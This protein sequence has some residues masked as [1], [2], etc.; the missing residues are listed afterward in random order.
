M[1][2]PLGRP[3]RH[4]FDL[5]EGSVFLN[6]GSYG[7]TPKS[8]TQARLAWLARIEANPDRFIRLDLARELDRALAAVARPV[9]GCDVTDLA[10]VT[11]SSVGTIA[12][13]NAIR[14]KQ[15]ADARRRSALAPPP[16]AAAATRKPKI[17]YVSTRYVA[18]GTAI[19]YATAVDG[20]EPLEVIVEYPI[21]DADLAARIEAAVQGERAAGGEVAVAIIDAISSVPGVVVP[22]RAL[23][24]LLRRLAVPVHVDAAHAAGQIPV[25]DVAELDPDFFVTNLHK[26]LYAPRSCAVIYVSPRMRPYICSPVITHIPQALAGR[27]PEENVGKSWRDAFHWPGTFDASN[28]LA[29]PAAVQFR[30]RLGGEAR[31]QA[32]CHDLAV[33]GGHLVASMW[34]THMLG[35]EATPPLDEKLCG[36]MCCVKIPDSVPEEVVS[37]AMFRLFDYNAAAV[38]YKEHNSW[39]ARLSAQPYSEM[40]TPQASVRK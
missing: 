27:T 37:S 3:M 16:T 15:A 2:P 18:V 7:A 40:K 28:W 8:V 11:N 32:Y 31:I 29:V 12:V 25:A 1:P 4:E 33:R 6:H 39:W 35:A 17:L 38:I 5:E 30:E 10:F 23:V 21:A 24:R 36:A 20:F 14:A 9:F 26:W 34:G 13:L 19:T 22:Y